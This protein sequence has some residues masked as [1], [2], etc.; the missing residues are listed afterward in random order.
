MLLIGIP[1]LNS[2]AAETW[3]N[4]LV[5][6]GAFAVGLGVFLIVLNSFISK[7]EDNDLEAYVHRQLTRS[8]SGEN[9]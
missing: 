8:R 7:Q 9:I 4:E 3:F 2:L 5:F 6:T 1:L